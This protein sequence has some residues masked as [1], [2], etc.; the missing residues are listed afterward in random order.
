MRKAER[1]QIKRD[2]LLTLFEKVSAYLAEN[3]RNVLLAGAAILVLVIGGMG[4]HA[5]LQSREAEASLLVGQMIRTYDAPIVG[6][7]QDQPV[8]QQGNTAFTSTD[9]RD[10][11]VL[12][13][14][15][16]ILEEH[17]TAAASP[18][19][20]YYKGLA[21]ADLRRYDEAIAA[22]EQVIKRY[23]RDFL[24]PMA[25]Y[26]MA[27]LREAEGK[28]GEALVQYQALVEDSG[29]L[30]PV[31]EGLLG[32]ARCHEALGDTAEALKIYQ[33]ILS[34]SSASEYSNLVRGKVAELS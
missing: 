16:I 4:L 22:L 18:K 2:D 1:H 10:R 25:R 29:G 21:L 33:R 12:E 15:D 28:P 7:A 11:K 3:Q 8:S 26:R 14:S 23:P 20:L 32:M 6:A 17:G 9:E 24:A 5:W 19:A 27:R 34:E 30:L 31:E 13:T